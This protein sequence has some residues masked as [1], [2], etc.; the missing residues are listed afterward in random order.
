VD[1]SASDALTPAIVGIIGAV[2]GA[3][4]GALGTYYI[5]K[6]KIKNIDSQKR[7][8]VYC[9][10]LGLKF[11]LS[12]VY[13]STY[14]AKMLFDFNMA[15]MKSSPDDNCSH[16]ALRLRNE[17]VNLINE[18]AKTEQYLWETISWS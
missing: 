5:E 7:Q 15:R 17:L 9:Q 13:S 3:C 2:L 1:A 4:A 18:T 14:Q 12:Q 16:E 8:Q 11:V 10:L 6:L